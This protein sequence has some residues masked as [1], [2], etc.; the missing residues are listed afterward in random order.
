MRSSQ[1]RAAALGV[2]AILLLGACATGRPVALQECGGNNC[3]HEKFDPD[4]R[5]L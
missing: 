4:P 1:I 3:R 5:T 2:I